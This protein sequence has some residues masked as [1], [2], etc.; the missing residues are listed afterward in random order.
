MN[1]TNNE[2][3]IDIF[4]WAIT[5]LITLVLGLTSMNAVLLTNIRNTQNSQAVE[6]A[7][8]KAIQDINTGN[9]SL[10]ANRVNTL[11]LDKIDAVKT[12]VMDNFVQK[13]QIK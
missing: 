1:T 7:R 3:K 13:G 4:K 12:W 8:M 6:L 5:I 11:E 2:K 10:L 9:I